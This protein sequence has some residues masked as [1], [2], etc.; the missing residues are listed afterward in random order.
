MGALRS[1]S[2][3]HVVGVSHH[4]GSCGKGVTSNRWLDFIISP[5]FTFENGMSDDRVR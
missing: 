2:Q 1:G 3:H 4:R 5:S